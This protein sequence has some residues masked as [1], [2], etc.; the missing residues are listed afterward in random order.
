MAEL[1]VA[2]DMGLGLGLILSG[3]VVL[4]VLL[5]VLVPLVWVPVVLAV[6]Q[7]VSAPIVGEPMMSLLKLCY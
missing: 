5:R 4:A 1:G 6:S 2:D 3:P 7:M